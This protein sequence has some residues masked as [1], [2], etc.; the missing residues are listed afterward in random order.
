[1]N[2]ER[3]ASLARFIDERWRSEEAHRLAVRCWCVMEDG[4]A[5]RSSISDA[6]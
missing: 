2:V 3:G 6:S 1:M 4:L 5:E